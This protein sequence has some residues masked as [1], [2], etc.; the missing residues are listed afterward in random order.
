M[1]NNDFRNRAEPGFTPVHSVDDT[2]AADENE[3]MVT[4]V[5]VTDEPVE[6]DNAF[7]LDKFQVVRREF[8]SHIS[9]P[10]ITFNNFKIGLNS[11]CI[12]RLPQIDYIQF[13]V[14]RQTQKLA[15][16]PCLESDLHSFQ[17]C[18][19]SGGKR[20][21]RQVTGR[22]FFM[23]LFDM[24][25]WNTS[26]RYKILGKLIRANGE[27]LFVFDLTSTEVYQRIVKEGA[28][29]RSAGRLYFQQN[30]RISLASR[31]KSIENPFKSISLIT[32]LY[33]ASKIGNQK[34]LSKQ[35]LPCMLS[36]RRFQLS[37][38]QEA[39]NHDRT[40][41]CSKYQHGT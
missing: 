19:N 32:M 28:S 2:A 11:A 16:R 5:P 21:P 35:I 26:Y 3:E 17:W 37:L 27:Y 13:L 18:T 38:L 7:S 6:E 8:F 41:E 24:M 31:M 23:K 9:E 4:V 22:I 20:K 15:I 10:S 34:L 30:G 12:K 14:N 40:V 25:G 29:R 33:T 39:Q 1:D 36:S